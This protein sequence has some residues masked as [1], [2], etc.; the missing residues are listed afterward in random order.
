MITSISLTSLPPHSRPPSPL[1]AGTDVVMAGVGG[2]TFTTDSGDRERGGMKEE[3]KRGAMEEKRGGDQKGR[4][5]GVY[6]KPD[7]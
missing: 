4:R 5:M 3:R 6:F 7:L 1:A 2:A